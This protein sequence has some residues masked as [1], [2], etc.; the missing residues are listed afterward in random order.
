[1][2]ENFF[3]RIYNKYIKTAKHRILYGSLVESVVKVFRDEL[4]AN[5]IYV[6]ASKRFLGKLENVADPEQ[7]RKILATS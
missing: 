5:L 7:K 2:I 1:M 3:I 4:H 6:D